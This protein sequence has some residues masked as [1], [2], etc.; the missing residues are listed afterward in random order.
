[1]TDIQR[2]IYEFG[3]WCIEEARKFGGDNIDGGDAEEQMVELGILGY[4]EVTEP[5]GDVCSC[6][7]WDDFP[8]ECLRFTPEILAELRVGEEAT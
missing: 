6:A 3:K 2:K 7:E 8:Q 1:M 4:V 5:C